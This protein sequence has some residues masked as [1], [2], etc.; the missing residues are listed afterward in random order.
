MQ[1]LTRSVDIHRKSSDIDTRQA[2]KHPHI[3][4]PFRKV[5]IAL[6]IETRFLD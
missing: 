3:I 6:A 5:L 1:I 2:Q 4:R